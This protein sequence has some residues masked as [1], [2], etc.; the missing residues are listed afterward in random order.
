MAGG[1]V[2]HAPPQ[3]I[4]RD[5]INE[6]VVRI[7]LEYIL[8][9]ICYGPFQSVQS[10]LAVFFRIYLIDLFFLFKQTIQNY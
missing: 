10:E 8:V 2:W 5:T 1:H 6:R 7:L 4:L 9:Y 3:Q